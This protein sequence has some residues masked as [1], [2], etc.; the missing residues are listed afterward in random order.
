MG[1]PA[2]TI[3]ARFLQCSVGDTASTGVVEAWLSDS[4]CDT[5]VTKK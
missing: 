2:G 1:V 5:E 3:G 4:P